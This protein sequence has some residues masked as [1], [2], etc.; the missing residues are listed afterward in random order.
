M[1]HN[2]TGT[3]K[4]PKTG[5]ATTALFATVALALAAGCGSRVDDAELASANGSGSGSGSTSGSTSGATSGT[6]GDASTTGTGFD[7]SGTGTGTDTGSTVGTTGSDTSTTGVPGAPGGSDTSAS[8]ATSTTGEPGT[9]GAP[10]PGTPG[11]PGPGTPGAPGPGTPAGVPPILGGSTASCAPATK[12][13]IKI[14]NVSTLSGVLG[15]LFSPV[16]PALNLFVKS[17]NACGGLNGH[18]MTL[19]LA[20]DQ[21]DPST[22]VTAVN[23]QINNDKVL[24]FVGNIQVLTVDAITPII[25]SK[26]IPIVGSDITNDTWYTNPYFF[27]QGAPSQAVSY[28]YIDLAK[29]VIKKTKIASIYCLEVPKACIGIDKAFGALAGP[30]GIQNVLQKQVSITATSYTS[31]CLEARSKGAEILT[32]TFDA[33]TQGRLANSCAG[34]NPP[35]KPQYIAYPLGVGNEDQF[36]GGGPNLGNTYVPLTSFHWDQN[37]TPASKYFQDSIKKFGFSGA[38]GNA[39]SLGWTAGALLVAATTKLPDDPSTEDILNGLYTIKDNNIAGLSASKLTFKKVESGGPA[40]SVQ[41]CY[42][43]VKSN[44]GN[45]AWEKPTTTPTCTNTRASTDP[46]K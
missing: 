39:A 33:A 34:L 45:T 31:Q 28:G 41:Y 40:G 43:S 30:L 3:R 23:R 6:S 37:D 46:N 1:D 7:T 18:P 5:W 13:P 21:G 32:L 26:K 2:K 9:P 10:G 19:S 4:R 25:N 36:F 42:F 35:F 16:V 44:A 20:D 12:S 14:G 27:P 15:E 22:A 11:A 38:N 8:S 29:R 17:Q 24:A